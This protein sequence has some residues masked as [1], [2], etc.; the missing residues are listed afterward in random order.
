TPPTASVTAPDAGGSYPLL[1]AATAGYTCADNVGIA[2]CTGTFA[3][4]SSL[5]ANTPGPVPFDVTAT[6]TSG[7]SINVDASYTVTNTLAD[8]FGLTGSFTSIPTSV[9]VTDASAPDGV[10]VAVPQGGTAPAVM[11]VC[12]G[13]SAELSPGTSATL[14][15]G[16][17]TVA[18][19]TGQ[20]K[21]TTPDATASMTVPAGGNARLD[22]NGVPQN[23]GAQPIV[24]VGPATRIAVAPA[25]AVVA[26]GVLQTFAVTT[27]DAY[28]QP[29]SDVTPTSTFVITPSG[30]CTVNVCRATTVGVRTVTATVGTMTA[31]AVLDVR[32]AQTIR[33]TAPTAKRMT[34]SPVALNATATSGLAVS[35]V[36]TT[37]AVCTVIGGSAILIGPGTCSVTAQQPGVAPWAP[38]PNVTRTFAVT[39]TAQTITF[40]T[41]PARTI[42]KSP[43][44]VTASASSSLPVAF[45]TT[46][47]AVCAA[48]GTNGSTIVLVDGGTCTVRADQPGDGV[49]A[50]APAVT[51][52]FAVSK[53]ANTITF[54]SIAKQMLPQSPLTLTATASSGLAVTF[55]TTTPA[56]CITSG[57]DGSSIMLIAPGTC[58]VHA[59]QSGDAIF[60]AALPVS[61]SFTVA[62]ATQ[63]ITFAVIANRRTTQSSLTVTG[64]ATSGLPVQFATTTPTVCAASGVNGSVITLLA[65]G[66]CTVRASQPGDASWSAAARVDRSFKV[67][68]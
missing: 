3:A 24:F 57:A 39:K 4:G 9:S 35:F 68:P 28:N 16:S 22:A 15:C 10:T 11:N 66:T 40:A 50:A 37:P 45:T 47:P 8:G 55:A 5:P 13:F 1:T 67:L 58:T 38:A 26:T 49:Y 2:T 60:K 43:V 21:V 34:E 30:T 61:R 63:A 23:L 25:V 46:T 31:T 27:F 29:L 6:D 44:V 18:V 52:S 36:S 64:T 33:F 41:L 53:L 14:T 32:K 62:K 42:D 7:N 59:S 56:V 65:V 48:T 20:V 54:A 12:G 51:R 19:T 17:V